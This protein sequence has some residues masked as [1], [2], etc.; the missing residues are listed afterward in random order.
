MLARWGLQS[1][2]KALDFSFFFF[3]RA[4]GIG[5]KNDLGAFVEVAGWPASRPRDT[6]EG[7]TRGHTDRPGGGDILQRHHSTAGT[8]PQQAK[9]A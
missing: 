9:Q 4:L 7:Q 5:R 8:A 2:G 6:L 3:G 1:L